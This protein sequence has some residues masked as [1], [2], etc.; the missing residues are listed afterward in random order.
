LKVKDTINYLI[1]KISDCY[2]PKETRSIAY[3][4]L[5]HFGI[6]KV[7][8]VLKGENEV[9]PDVCT[10]LEHI[11]SE[12]N[13]K[14]P[15]QYILGMADFYGLKFHVNEHVLI[16]RSETEELVDLI[17][18]ENSLENPKIVDIGTGSGCIAITI[19]KFIHGS[20]IT[21]T[22][23]SE[24]CIETSKENAKSCEVNVEFLVDDIF[25]TEL[26]NKDAFDILVSNPPY[27]TESEKIWMHRN[28]LEYEPGVA[29]FVPDD[30]P[31]MYYKKIVEVGKDILKSGGKIYVEINERFG[32]ATA[33]LFETYG[34]KDIMIIK[35]IHN[36]DRIVKAIKI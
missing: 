14:K 31:L 10:Q 3:I 20:I 19:A 9:D 16:P 24:K 12:L 7:D 15:V 30:D 25:D 28:V 26:H 18:K 29:L 11:G 6:N 2:P 8:L 34:F 27:V 1:D 17:I 4:V 35:D 5:E 22:D 36:K 33:E 21:A 13:K 32:Q 23:I